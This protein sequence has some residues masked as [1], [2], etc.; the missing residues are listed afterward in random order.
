MARVIA[1]GFPHHAT[2]RGNRREPIFFE[3][4]DQDIYCDLLAEHTGRYHVAVWAYCLMPNHVH[5]ILVPNDENGLARAIGAAHHRYTHF[6]NARGRWTG[7]LFQNRFGSLVM[8]DAHLVAGVR[9]V[10]LNPVRARLV[11]RAED[12]PWSSVRAHL[13]G[14]ED[15]LVGV[16]PVLDRIA[17][18][19]ERRRRPDSTR[20]VPPKAPAGR[21][22]TPSSSPV[23]NESSGGG[24]QSARPDASRGKAMTA[25]P[26]FCSFTAFESR[27]CISRP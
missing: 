12:W 2:H 4:G 3:H 15:G 22:A 26:H 27:K 14:E 24:L 19:A 16:R 7:H 17:N 11:A 5:L 13:K 10:S 6:I 1:S 8:D 18:F 20:C 9:Y 21:S 23:S 25:K